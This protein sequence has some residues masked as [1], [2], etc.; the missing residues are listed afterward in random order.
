M[1][2]T[3][4]AGSHK[5]DLPAAVSALIDSIP[6]KASLAGL[7]ALAAKVDDLAA[8]VAALEAAPVPDPEPTPAPLPVDDLVAAI[9]ATPNGGTLDCGGASFAAPAGGFDLNRSIVLRNAF[10]TSSVVSGS[11]TTATLRVTAANAL[12]DDVRLR[13]GFVGI[14]LR[15]DEVVVRGCAVRDVV[16]AGI[17]TLSVHDCLAIDNLVDGVR[18][19]S[20]ANGWNAY[21]ITAT[22]LSG[23]PISERVWIRANTV[24]N[25][26]TW[27]G[28]DTHGGADIHVL[29]N[30]IEACRRGIFLTDAP[31]HVV[32]D[33]NV[34]TC[35]TA[36]EQAQTPPG[37]APASYLTDV[38]GIS[39]AG[40]SGEI[41]NNIG[42]G[43][44]ASRWWNPISPG[45]YTFDANS[46]VIP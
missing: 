6:S 30:T 33:G 25:I 26:P 23:E 46:P 9:A 17:L 36:A 20:G 7:D 1:S 42:H 43:Y 37:G 28:I 38:R 10:L 16:Y 14:L 11:A 5:H 3:N 31:A 12:V 18:P 40:G 44:P 29:D 2:A 24:R 27:H 19:A 32:C 8:R 45:A 13:G 41:A 22:N 4:S 15:A 21:G 35:P 34:L 39:V